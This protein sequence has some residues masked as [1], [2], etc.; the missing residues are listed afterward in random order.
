MQEGIGFYTS[1]W[2]TIQMYL[3]DY[4]EDNL[5][6]MAKRK[7]MLSAFAQRHL[8]KLTYQNIHGVEMEDVL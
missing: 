3:F 2:F 4:I 6:M 8:I 5:G 7:K 1:Q